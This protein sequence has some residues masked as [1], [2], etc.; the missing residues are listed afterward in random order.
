MNAQISFSAED[1]KD[2]LSTPKFPKNQQVYLLEKEENTLDTLKQQIDKVYNDKDTLNN[3]NI[4]ESKNDKNIL[5]N[6]LINSNTNLELN[7]IYINQFSFDEKSSNFLSKKEEN[8]NKENNE[9]N[10][11]DINIINENINENL[12]EKNNKEEN[13]NTNNNQEEEK[14]DNEI[15]YINILTNEDMEKNDDSIF[16][17]ELPLDSDNTPE[18]FKMDDF[19]ENNERKKEIDE[20]N[21]EKKLRIEGI[22]KSKKEKN[23]KEKIEKLNLTPQKKIKNKMDRITNCEQ[24]KENRNEI[25]KI[26][27]K[28]KDKAYSVVKFNTSNKKSNKIFKL[29]KITHH[30]TILSQ[31]YL[32]KPSIEF[33]RLLEENEEEQNN[34]LTERNNNK[35]NNLNTNNNSLKN[36]NFTSKDINNKKCDDKIKSNDNGLIKPF[37]IEQSSDNN[38][39]N[40]L[41][42]EEN[43]YQKIKVN[44]NILKDNTIS[45]QNKR[46]RRNRNSMNFIKRNNNFLNFN[47][48]IDKTKIIYEKNLSNNDSRSFSISQ[49]ENESH[50]HSRNYKELNNNINNG[51]VASTNYLMN[52]RLKNCVILLSKNKNVNIFNECLNHD[53]SLKNFTLYENENFSQRSLDKNMAGKTERSSPFRKSKIRDSFILKTSSYKKYILN[54]DKLN[55]YNSNKNLI[56]NTMKNG[57]TKNFEG[58]N[59]FEN[60]EEIKKEKYVKEKINQSNIKNNAVISR[61]YINN[62]IFKNKGNLTQRNKDIGPANIYSKKIIFIPNANNNNETNNNNYT[63][64]L[65]QYTLGYIPNKNKTLKKREIN[66]SYLIP[67]EKNIKILNIEKNNNINE[68]KEKKK[69]KEYFHE[70]LSNI[71]INKS[72]TKTKS[73]LNNNNN[74][75]KQKEQKEQKEKHKIRKIIQLSNLDI[76][77]MKNKTIEPTNKVKNKKFN[78][79]FILNKI[80]S[81][82]IKNNNYI[83]NNKD[84]N[85]NNN[86]LF[87]LTKSSKNLLEKFKNNILNYSINRNNRINQVKNEVSLFIGDNNKKFKKIINEK[88]SLVN[89]INNNNNNKINQLNKN[90]KTIIN[91]N[92]YYSS[93]FIKK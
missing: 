41:N 16:D 14:N 53:N 49:K 57:G 61:N 38:K 37:T 8:E 26:K 54:K 76:K 90:K 17:Y 47:T 32:I 23:S 71:N 29:T 30:K 70:I 19:P 34:S 27:E 51:T 84:N 48:E 18:F 87:S 58:Y 9:N 83:K 72:I 60:I 91:V 66:K 45:Y 21:S 44:S 5:I 35:S 56:N 77:T 11:K 64:R 86:Y 12:N 31:N 92:Q 85:T 65:K 36:T 52:K 93:Y 4:N 1:I 10:N 24:L 46:N 55:D 68:D 88:K 13:N 22:P 81:N 7:N 73:N 62:T 79:K 42:N 82:K 3:E 25:L 69:Y 2:N 28:Q 15:K 20:K 43:I 6:S 89:S 63:N 75:M 67:K 74:N 50:S 39:N 33:M 78:S 40:N 80:N 59:I